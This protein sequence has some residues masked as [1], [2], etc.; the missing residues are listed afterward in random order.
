MNIVMAA[1]EVTPFAKT[2]GLADV[3]GAV[4]KSLLALGHTVSVFMPLYKMVRKNC[5]A[6]T[7]TKAVVS[8]PVGENVQQARIFKAFLPGTAVPTYLVEN[9]RYY[10]RDALYGKEGKDFPDNSE[11]FIFFSRAVLEAVSALRIPCDV[12]HCHDWQTALIPVYLKTIY[13]NAPGLGG[14]GSVFTIH[15]LAFQGLFWHWDMKLTGLDWS[16]FNCKQLEFWGKVNFMKGGLVFADVLNTVSETYAREIQTTDE[17]GCGLE[18][19]LRDRSQDLYGVVNGIDYE[20]WNPATDPLIPAKYDAKK[21]SGKAACKKFLQRKCGLPASR[22]PLIGMIG[23]LTDQKGFDLAAEVME[24]LLTN[25]IQFVVLGTGEPKYHDLLNRLARNYP[26]RM[27][28]TLGFDNQLAHEI[29]AGADM[30]LMPSRFEPCGL[31]QLYS[32]K[33]GTVPIVRRTGGLADTVMDCTPETLENGTATGFCFE[34]YSAAELLATVKRAIAC[35]ADRKTWLKLMKNGMAQN[36]SWVESA[37][38]YVKLYELAR[39]K[40][41]M[42]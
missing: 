42:K 32:L 15:N 33:Y 36:W 31:N 14:V 40:A 25:K 35:Y 3:V 6:M 39:Q 19:V 21:L 29:E 11:R 17:Y 9:D 2:G 41:Q 1:S 13:R 4:P 34:K 24:Q 37:R 5:A 28:V 8:V 10:M 23:R 20:V 27:G 18:G 7:D 22:V 38:R 30:F 26:D 16:F 12:I